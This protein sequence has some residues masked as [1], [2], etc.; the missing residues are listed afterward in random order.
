MRGTTHLASGLALATIAPEI[1]LPVTAGLAIGAILPDI[2]KSSSLIGRYIPVIPKIFKHRTVTHNLWFCAAL[3]FFSPPLA[4]GCLLHILLDMCNPDGIPLFWPVKHKFHVPLISR[5]ARSGDGLITC[6]AERSGCITFT[7][8]FQFLSEH[9]SALIF[10]TCF[11]P[12][13]RGECFE[14]R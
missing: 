14:L 1:S 4:L 10:G 11:E 5:F 7:H 8:L 2:D 13:S 12:G 6:L 9:G 3:W